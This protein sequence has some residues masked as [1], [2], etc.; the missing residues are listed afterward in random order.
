M[1]WA[2]TWK[3]FQSLGLAEDLANVAG[4][5]IDDL[6][7]ECVCISLS[8]RVD[9]FH[10]SGVGLDFRKSDQPEAGFRFALFEPPSPYVYIHP[11]E[12]R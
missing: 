10:T 1:F 11:S 3:I 8:G 12:M 9:E 5:P 6:P 7:S 2:R 4:S